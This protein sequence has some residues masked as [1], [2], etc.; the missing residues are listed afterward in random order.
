MAR[1]RDAAPSGHRAVL[2]NLESDYAEIEAWYRDALERTR[3]PE[4][5][6]TTA[7]RPVTIGPTWQA[8][9]SG[10]LLS[11]IPEH[12]LG[13]RWL[14]WAGRWLRGPDGGPWVYTME[15]ARAILHWQEVDPSDVVDGQPRLVWP[16]LFLQRLKGWGKDPLAG[17][18]SLTAMCGPWVPTIDA[19]GHIDGEPHPDAWVQVAATSQEQTETTLKTLPGLVTPEARSW[20][21]IDIGSVSARAMGNTRYLQAV[22]SNYLAIEGKRPTLVIQNEAQNW[23]PSNQGHDM[24][25]AIDGNLAKAPRSRAARRIYICNAYQVGRDSVAQRVREGW[26][27]QADAGDPRSAG[28]LVDSLEAPPNAPLTREAAPE[29]IELV[30]GDSV[31]LDPDRVM[32]S[33]LSLAVPPSESRRK[34]YNQVSAAEDSWLSAREWDACADPDLPPLEQ[35]DETLVFFDGGKSDDATALVGCRISDGAVFVLGLW[36]RPPDARAH[37]WVAPRERVDAAVR[38]LLDRDVHSPAA[39]AAVV[40]LW[41][42]PSHAREDETL[43]LYWQGLVDQWHRDYGSGLRLWARG[44]SKRSA[45]R[46]HATLWDM[47]E[48]DNHRAFVAAVGQTTEDVLSRDLVHDGDAR[49]RGHVLHARRWPT[50]H[51][52]SIGKS[53]RESRR[54]IDLAVAMVGA[55]LMR[56]EWLNSRR[57][58]K[59]LSLADWA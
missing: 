42:D 27:K 3:L 6:S 2:T 43:G 41:A 20:Y 4:A 54:K 19:R 26:E 48:S 33:V 13:W 49:L 24:D 9:D 23:L 17:A 47:S 15:Q 44:A 58:R 22:T 10:S 25:L 14:S 39:G 34:W 36:Q 1:R 52:V 53:H 16:G 32:S 37:G 5:W 12:T 51:G 28:L 29:V 11:T 56:R 8:D 57:G 45:S 21:G 50:R 7:Y 55:R 35:G 30:R 38:A 18:V 40:G 59:S 46:G 31:W